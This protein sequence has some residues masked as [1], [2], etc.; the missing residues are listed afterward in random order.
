[1]NEYQ[2]LIFPMLEKIDKNKY[3]IQNLSNI[4]DILLPKL[5]CREVEVNFEK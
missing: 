4:R 1:M 3:Q 2:N 5:M